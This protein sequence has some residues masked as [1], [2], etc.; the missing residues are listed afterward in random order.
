MQES[1][2]KISAKNLKCG[3]SITTGERDCIAVDFGIGQINHKTIKSYKFDQVKLMSDLTYS[4]EASAIVLSDFKKKY[5]KNDSEYWTRYNA[6]VKNTPTVKRNR[7]I[8]KN[9]VA[10][11][12]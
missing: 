4:V 1:A 3:I 10:R 5:G 6:G 11:Y 9:L 8:Y 7:A 2:Y 12:L